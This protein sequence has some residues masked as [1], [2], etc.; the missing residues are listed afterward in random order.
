M[1]GWTVRD[2]LDVYNVTNWGA[3]FFRIND[4]GFIIVDE[5]LRTTDPRIFAAGD[6]TGPPLLT[7]CAL[8]QG[9]VEVAAS[10][11]D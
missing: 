11:H 5:T 4:A 2:S 8:D 3:D 9:R 6:V 10:T 1:R 7:M